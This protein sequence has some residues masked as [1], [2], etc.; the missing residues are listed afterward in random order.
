MNR[1]TIETVM[2][3]VVL[4]AA[5]VFLWLTYQVTDFRSSDQVSLEAVF[6]K[7]GD[8][9]AG[10]DVRIAGIKVGRVTETK[11]DPDLYQAMV[12]FAIDPEVIVP[13]D[14]IARIATSSLLGGSYVD[15]IPG[16]GDEMMGDGDIFYDT[17]NPVDLTDLIGKAIFRSGAG[18]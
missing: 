2:G 18:N 15:I 8:L 7:V 4:I 6:G 14:S 17:R 5:A 1:N 12:S 13:A 9:S 11:L 16:N 10:D 3:A